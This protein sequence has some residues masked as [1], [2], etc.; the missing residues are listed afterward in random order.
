MTDLQ[1]PVFRLAS[2][3]KFGPSRSLVWLREARSGM[4][5]FAR[6][7]P[8]RR[9]RLSA[10]KRRQSYFPEPVDNRSTRARIERVAQSIAEQVEGKNGEKNCQSRPHCHPRR[11]DQKA[12]RGIEHAAPRRRGRLLAKAE[13]GQR[14][15]GYDR[16]GDGKRRLHQ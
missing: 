9:S 16:G 4:P 10:A 3:T 6:A 8:K 15:L 13:E 7:E 1:F 14:R 11:I 5:A 2:C 12:L